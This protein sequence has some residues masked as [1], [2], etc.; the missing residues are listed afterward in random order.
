MLA[1]RRRGGGQLEVAYEFMG[2]R[3]VSIVDA[4]TLQVIDSG[5]CLAGADALVTLDSLPG[6][7][8]EAIDTDRLVIT[9]R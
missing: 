4:L 9:R 8:R 5:V 1:A 3:F 7:I 2:E 6:V